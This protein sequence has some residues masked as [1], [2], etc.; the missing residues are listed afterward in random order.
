MEKVHVS[1]PPT[2][3]VISETEPHSFNAHRTNYNSPTNVHLPSDSSKMYVKSTNQLP[4]QRN[5]SR[6][7]QGYAGNSQSSINQN[8]S[9]PSVGGYV[10]YKVS[11][12]II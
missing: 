11:T 9:T 7:N 3:E 10:T 6:I 2:L 4:S 8:G 1:R 5:D 12:F